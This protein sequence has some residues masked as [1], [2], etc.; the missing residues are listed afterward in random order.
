MHGCL[1]VLPPMKASLE[2]FITESCLIILPKM[3]KKPPVRLSGIL[4]K[5]CDILPLKDYDLESHD[6]HILQAED[7][8]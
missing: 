4:L 6:H 1:N 7:K 8:I 3:L 2:V 5:S